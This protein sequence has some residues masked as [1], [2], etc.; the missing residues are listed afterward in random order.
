MLD[1][2]RDLHLVNVLVGLAKL[3]TVSDLRFSWSAVVFGGELSF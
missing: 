2:Y 3:L 1:E